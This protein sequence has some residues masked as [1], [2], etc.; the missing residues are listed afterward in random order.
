MYVDCDANYSKV[1]HDSL[2]ATAC[3]FITQQPKL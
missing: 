2:T 3:Q 1:A